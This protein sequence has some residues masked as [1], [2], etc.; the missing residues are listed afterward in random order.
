MT[1]FSL[2]RVERDEARRVA[3]VTL[4]RPDVHNA[5]N[6]D[7]RY[8]LA[9]AFDEIAADERIGAL[10]LTGAGAKSFSV[11]ADLKNPESNHSVTDFARY[12]PGKRQKGAWY[13]TLIAYPK[14]VVSAVNGYC[15]GS[16]LQ[17][18]MAA[19]ILVASPNATFWL[20]QTGLG[21]APHVPTLVRMARSMGQQRV[22]QM[23]LTGR[24]LD[25]ESA[26]RY[27]L[28][29]DVVAQESLV[30]TAIDLAAAIAAKPALSIQV[31]KESFLQGMELAWEQLTRV[32]A[33]KEFCMYQNDARRASH[34]AFAGRSARG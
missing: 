4:D 22:M 9:A 3:V 31:T 27:G 13:D 30:A 16:G 11:G 2:I 23:A 10:V 29:S 17:L 32:D 15:A 20:P 21:L 7:I 19:D 24:R 6:A 14:G 34:D 12:M 8:E 33:W 1:D 18:A 26:L 25:A 28:I 5:L